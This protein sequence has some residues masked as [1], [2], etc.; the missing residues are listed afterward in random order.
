MS[1]M[2]EL[3][4]IITPVFNGIKYL[5]GCVQSVLEQDYPHI[6]HVFIDAGSADGTVELLK[7]YSLKYPGRIRFLSEPDNG[8]GD[9]WNKGLK[10]AKGSI[11]GCLG[12]DDLYTPDAVSTVV[13]FLTAHPEAFFVHANC[14]LING[15][16]EVI[17]RHNVRGFDYQAFADTALHISTTSAF[18]RREVME[19]IGWLDSSGDDFDVMLRITKNFKAYGIDKVISSL[20]I[21]DSFFN[22]DNFHKRIKMYRQTYEVSRKYG[23]RVFSPLALRYYI[24]LIIN[25]THLEFAFPILRKSYRKLRRI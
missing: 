25:R 1:G 17:G 13:E 2:K 15:D 7:E 6:E 3:V 5:E 4:S 22:P 21:H 11:F 20:R 14:D 10:M 12:Y 23:G 24:C 16:G 19:K 9:G 8:P 18:Y